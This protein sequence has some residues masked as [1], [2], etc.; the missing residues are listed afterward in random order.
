MS[1][2]CINEIYNLDI[3]YIKSYWIHKYFTILP[4]CIFTLHILYP[5]PNFNKIVLQRRNQES[6]IP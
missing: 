3:F 6:S 5:C 1:L 4:N 2:R